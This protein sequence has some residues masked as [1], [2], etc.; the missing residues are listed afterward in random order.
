[1]ASEQMDSEIV[2]L[3]RSTMPWLSSVGS[4]V[5]I[6]SMVRLVR[7]LVD[8]RFPRW[9]TNEQQLNTRE[10]VH[11]ALADMS[12][13]F[14]HWRME[15]LSRN[16]RALFSERRIAGRDFA[17]TAELAEIA[18]LDGQ[19]LAFRINDGDHLKI[20]CILPGLDL[21]A[22]YEHADSADN[23]ISKR[24]EFAFDDKKGFLTSDPSDMGTGLR[25]SA[26]LFLPALSAAE[27]IGQITHAIQQL[28]C[29]VAGFSGVGSGFDGC[30]FQIYNRIT[31]GES[32]ETILRRM[33]GV[34][35][36]IV[37]QELAARNELENALINLVPDRMAR[38][39][40]MLCSARVVPLQEG[41]GL[42][43][44][45]RLAACLGYIDGQFIGAVDEL[46]TAIL[47]THLQLRHGEWVKEAQQNSIR[48]EILRQAF[49]KV[50]MLR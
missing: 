41:L 44:Q 42:L 22:A 11:G 39:V 38:V 21:L 8:E 48:A 16:E 49:A 43:G 40:A 17:K 7:D 46:M 12:P 20:S 24:L 36:T 27:K 31:L 6:S 29:A 30:I 3:A 19:T 32:E 33:I 25:A 9:A 26:L 35:E 4:P 45:A 34:V 28:G 10:R 47:P 15:S 23:A 5:V 14:R 37:E 13:S 2:A 50:Q 1:M 18:V